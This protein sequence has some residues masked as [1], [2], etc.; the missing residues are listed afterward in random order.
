M[1]ESPAHVL[2]WAANWCSCRILQKAAGPAIQGILGRT[3][4]LLRIHLPRVKTG[5]KAAPVKGG[6]PIVDT[7]QDE[8]FSDTGR[9]TAC[10]SKKQPPF[11]PGRPKTDG[12]Q[13]DYTDNG[14]GTVTD[15]VTGLMWQKGFKVMGYEKALAYAEASTVG[16]Y[17]D[18][19][20]PT[21]KELYSLI[22]FSGVDA[23][24]R[25]MESVPSGAEPY[26]DSRVFDFRYGANGNRPIDTQLVSSTLYTDRTMGGAQTV[27]GVNMADGRIK[28]ISRGQSQVRI[29]K[30]VHRPSRQGPLPLWRQLFF[31]RRRR[32]GHR[33]FHGFDVGKTGQR[34]SHGLEGG[35][36]LG[37]ITE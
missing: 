28:R 2:R 24:S 36:G 22:L 14:N 34:K 16:G 29:R 10:P 33:F 20:L 9:K 27:F 11:R 12:R 23:S 17:N 13:P 4:R 8:C 25:E 21:I 30:E 1:T 5:R 15:N 35:A 26:M 7:G 19:R 31:G 6:Y 37:E 32:N 3:A 18:W